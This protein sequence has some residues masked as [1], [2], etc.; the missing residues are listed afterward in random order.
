MLK[1]LKGPQDSVTE[2][3]FAQSRARG[4]GEL[5]FRTE[6]RVVFDYVTVET[7][8]TVLLV[9]NHTTTSRLDSMK[10][11]M[12][13][14]YPKAGRKNTTKSSPTSRKVKKRNRLGSNFT[15]KHSIINYKKKKG[16]FP[17]ELHA[18]QKL[19]FPFDGSRPMKSDSKHS[20][21]NWLFH[22]CHI[23][24]SVGGYA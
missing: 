13:D 23:S 19:P 9:L 18:S 5:G 8:L 3:A 6:I 11:L 20:I 14:K 2:L 17:T 21:D 7:K 22:R 16:D 15:T 4:S 12:L 10:I 1:T 24:S